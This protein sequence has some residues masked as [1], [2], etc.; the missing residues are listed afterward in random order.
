VDIFGNFSKLKGDKET[1]KIAESDEREFSY[2]KVA[3]P[4]MGKLENKSAV[5]SLVLWKIITVTIFCL[6]VGRLFV[7]TVVQK[8]ANEKL[9]EGNRVR[10]RVIDASRGLI[11]DS[12][13]NW[14]VRNQPSF[15]LAVY[16]SDLPRKKADREAIYQKLAP[17]C[18][19]SADDIRVA[20][21]KNGF[22]SLDETDIKEN[23]SHDD[24][25]LAEQAVNGIPGVFVAQKSIRQYQTGSGLGHILGYTGIVSPADISANPVYYLS[26]RIGKVGLEDQYESA[27]KGK[28]GLEEIMVNSKGSIVQ[29]QASSDNKEPVAG[30]DITLYLN[31]ALQQQVGN[32]L[33]QGIA[34]GA[35]TTGQPISGAVAAVMDVNTGGIL[36]MVSTPDYNDNLFST[37]ISSA[38]YQKLINDPTNPMFDRA[39]QGTYP[40]GSIS[41]IILASAGLAEGNITQNTS[42]VTPSAIKI[43]D[44]T[45]PD[46][47]DHSYESTNVERAL[48]ESND[49][50]FYSVGGGF[51]KI[52][53]LGIDKIKEYWQKFGLGEKTGIDL[54][55]EAS[56]LLPDNAWK[57]KTQG[58]PWYLG[59][60]YHVSIGQGD[61]LVTPLQMLRATAAIANGGK[62]LQPQLVEKIT[63]PNGKV[64]QQFGPR[65]ENPQVADPS[66]IKTVQAGMRMVVTDGSAHSIFPNFPIEVA[67]KTGTAQFLDNQKTHAW[68]ECYAPYDNPQ[69]AVIVL[70]EG[71][72][73]GFDIAAP[74]A[75]NILQYYFSQPATP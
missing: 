41:K 59:D 2:S 66:V 44:Y 65:V 14:L 49:I 67:G 60:T 69:I 39:I 34:V 42:M 21:E 31:N 61:L 11:F 24:A 10:P 43:G 12:S 30:N 70:V 55:G 46:W 16:P 27:L 62:L 73:E 28:D 33:N 7:L 22:F 4:T 38:D 29:V 68:F 64:V 54:P 20:A 63:D 3:V 32:F 19:M 51:D 57:K 58:Q 72:G 25:L 75:K 1:R 9:A 35:Q 53:G 74:V 5:S 36:A 6:L 26:E 56:G 18:Q 23:I 48:S 13:G 52:K 45:F 15:A 71:G 8:N 17:I 37:K 40:P 47:K 50:F